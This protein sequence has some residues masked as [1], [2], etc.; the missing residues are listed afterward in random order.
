MPARMDRCATGLWSL[1]GAAMAADVQRARQAAREA[2][3]TLAAACSE[4]AGV[5]VEEVGGSVRLGGM[6]LPLRA[7]LLPAVRGLADLLRTLAVEAVVFDAGVPAAALGEWAGVFAAALRDRRSPPE[8]AAWGDRPAVRWRLR[9]SVAEPVVT[10]GR[11]AAAAEP[12]DSR[13]RAVFL[14]CRLMAGLDHAGPVPPTVAKIVVQVVV[15]KLLG[16]PGGLEPLML[17]QQDESLLRRGTRVAVLAV[18]LAR[19][20]GWPDDRLAELGAAA[21]LHDIGAVLDPS[22]PGQ[23]AFAWLL[24]RGTD[25]FWLRSALLARCWREDHGATVAAACYA[26]SGGAAVVRLAATMA[27]LL[28]Q[29]VGATEVAVRIGAGSAAGEF[30]R[31]LAAV[32]RLALQAP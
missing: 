29:G 23:A 32:G 11:Q 1:V 21:L 4:G 15:E 17:L 9:R 3:E 12:A 19:M 8:S 13:L 27:S 18:V 6:A 5:C 7:D 10:M 14:Q 31:E 16:V 26:D 24:E 2:A 25:D 20:A 28:D 30:P 22:R